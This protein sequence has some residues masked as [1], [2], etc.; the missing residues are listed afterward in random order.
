MFRNFVQSS[1]L[2]SV[3]YER[4]TL[5]IEF[6]SGGLYQFYGVSE[7]EYKNLLNASSL[8]QYFHYKIKDKYTYR[9]IS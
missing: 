1:N 8:G 2:R 3:G 6:R 9:K 5:E 4:G 7:I